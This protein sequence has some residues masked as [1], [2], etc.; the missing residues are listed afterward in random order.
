MFRRFAPESK[1]AVAEARAVARRAGSRTVEAE[2]LLLALAGGNG[3]PAAAALR[4]AGLD[5]D[6]IAA[7]LK[8]EASHSLAAAGLAIIDD[9]RH[10]CPTP[11]SGSTPDW[12]PSAKAALGRAVKE[13]KLRGHRCL[14]PEHVLLGVLHSRYGRVSRTLDVAG[15]SRVELFADVCSRLN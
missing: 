13:A 1:A 12:G 15:V 2:H 5:A 10:P 8:E 6:R 4:D 11:P 14:G 3:D 7:A 9:E